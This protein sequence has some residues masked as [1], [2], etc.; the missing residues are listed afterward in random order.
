VSWRAAARGG[1]V[2]AATLAVV[3]CGGKSS[4]TTP[5]EDEAGGDDGGVAPDQGAG[6]EGSTEAGGEASSTDG[7]PSYTSACT[8]L[9]EQTGTAINTKHGRLDG[10]LSY[11]VPQG[12]PVSCNGDDSHVHLQIEVSGLVYDVAVDIGSTEDGS[13]GNYVGMEQVTMAVPGGAWAEGWHGSDDLSYGSLGVTA[14]ALP[15]TDPPTIASQLEAA[16]VNTSKI[17]IFCTGYSEGDGC[18]DVHYENGDGKDGAIVLD[19]TAAT[20]P[21]LF[22]RFDG[23][24]F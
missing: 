22:F 19:P 7:T 10:Y 13:D 21:V 11:V 12:G 17:A 23:Q 15:I 3:T 4:Q 2:L 1:Y 8:P 9:S 14:S 6:T 24:T 20:S 18:H 5:A 16:L